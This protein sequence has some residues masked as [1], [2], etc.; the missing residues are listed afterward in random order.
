MRLAL[1][2]F[3]MNNKKEVRILFR[4][5]LT[6]LLY[7]LVIALFLSLLIGILF[8]YTPLSEALLPV[9]SGL[10]I[11][12][13]V[14]S[15]SLKAARMTGTR[16][17]LQGLAVGF[18]FFIVTAVIGWTSAPFIASAVGKKLGICLLAGAMGGIAGI[19]SQ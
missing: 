14:F 12:L 18:F 1:H 19:A 15:G 7:T 2:K 17:L 8:Y 10:I 11:A 3:R 4:A 16:G 6:G 9:L 13:A 5:T